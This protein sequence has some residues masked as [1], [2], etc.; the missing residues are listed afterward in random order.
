MARKAGGTWGPNFLKVKE[1]AIAHVR[2][3]GTH[4]PFQHG[5]LPLA[6][7]DLIS[8]LLGDVG[9]YLLQDGRIYGLG[10][11]SAAMKIDRGVANRGLEV[12]AKP[13]PLL[14]GADKAIW[15]R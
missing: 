3:Q 8:I 13:P 4:G 9:N 1:A 5:F 14:P 12:I 15:L 7:P 11:T 10:E 2:R 6:D